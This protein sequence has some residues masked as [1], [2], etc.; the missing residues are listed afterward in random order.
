MKL[1]SQKAASTRKSDALRMENPPFVI[2]GR[3][4][5][6]AIPPEEIADDGEVRMGCSA[7]DGHF[8]AF[9]R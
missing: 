2:D 3:P 4:L 9:R 7:L 5:T 1:K 8:P 6:L